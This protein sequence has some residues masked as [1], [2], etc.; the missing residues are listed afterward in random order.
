MGSR[1]DIDDNLVIERYNE[2]KNLKKV[3]KSFGVSVR[4][5]KR[6]LKKNDIHLTNRKYNVN[7]SFFKEIDSEEKAYWLGF[8]F[9]DGCVRQTKHGSQVILKLSVKD[10]GHLSKFKKNI[11]SEHKIVYDKSH[12]I[13]KKGTL[14]TSNNCLI[15]VNSCE[16]VNDL[17][18]Q[19]CTPKKTFIIDKPNIE[20]K[21]YK[22]FLRG[23]YD[24]DGNFFYN[25][26]TKTSVITIVCASKEFRTFIVEILSKLPNIGK[27]HEDD[28]KYTIKITNIVGIIKF[29]SYIYDESK[30]EL[31][32]KKEYYEK[33][34]EY[35]RGIESDYQ[36]G[37]RGGYVKTS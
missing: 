3:A 37:L 36:R 5:V 7:H 14:S 21:Y 10:K 31:T 9:A 20:E 19:G 23:Y 17:I 16:M 25:E 6:I 13:S 30:I 35:R 29:L 33:Y 8:L 4:P 28:K 12:V 34:R 24:G 11:K 18:K 22:H 1:I 2:L 15:R 32:R 27:I 26:K